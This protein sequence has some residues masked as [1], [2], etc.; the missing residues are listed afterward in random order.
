M[1]SMPPPAIH[2]SMTATEWALLILLATLW[3]G[4]YFYIGVAVKSLPP[5]AIV[6][7]RVTL[8]AALLYLVVR[9]SGQRMPTKAV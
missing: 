4:S 3:G 6:A 8:G 1:T 5:L 2:K 7:F 9:V